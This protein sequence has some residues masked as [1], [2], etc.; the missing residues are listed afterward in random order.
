MTTKTER[1][2]YGTKSSFTTGADYEAGCET[3]G[4]TAT[5]RNGILLAAQH[6]GQTGHRVTCEVFYTVVWKAAVEPGLPLFPE[7]AEKQ[8][9]TE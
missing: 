8:A 5:T 9:A 6:H 1:F 2:P 3:C 4:W 7:E